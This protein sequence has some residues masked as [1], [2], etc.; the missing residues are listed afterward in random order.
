MFKQT[1]IK[2][3]APDTNLDEDTTQ[4]TIALALACAAAAPAQTKPAYLFA[5]A[6]LATKRQQAGI[7]VTGG[8]MVATN[9]YYALTLQGRK[10]LANN[11]KTWAMTALLLPLFV[12]KKQEVA[13]KALSIAEYD[14]EF[15]LDKYRWMVVFTD[16]TTQ[17][18]ETCTTDG[19]MS[20]GSVYVLHTIN[21]I[22]YYDD[23]TVLH[24]DGIEVLAQPI[25][26]IIK[27]PITF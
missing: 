12:Q 17:T 4:K 16:G 22:T 11:A 26:K 13:T 27:E 10:Y 25:V 23:G 21:G 6:L 19:I 8:T 1:I 9:L 2:F 18:I 7:V 5:V 3:F 14:I 15:Q 20:E 24:P